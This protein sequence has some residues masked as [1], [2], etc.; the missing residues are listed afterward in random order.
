[1]ILHQALSKN[2]DGNFEIDLHVIRQMAK[3]FD[4]GTVTDETVVAKFII[5][6]YEC[7]FDAGVQDCEENHRKMALLMM[8][9]GGN[10]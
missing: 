1:M 5:A 3:A 6:A 8:C 10:A 4:D 9:T 7:G 2:S